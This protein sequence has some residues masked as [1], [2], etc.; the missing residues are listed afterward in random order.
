MERRRARPCVVVASPSNPSTLPRA[1]ALALL[2]SAGGA[3]R[4]ELP[5]TVSQFWDDLE[6]SF[7]WPAPAVLANDS[8]CSR[9][10]RAADD[11]WI[12]ARS[13]R[14]RHENTTSLPAGAGSLDGPADVAVRLTIPLVLPARN[15]CLRCLADLWIFRRNR[16]RP[17]HQPFRN[18]HCLDPTFQGSCGGRL[19]F[20]TDNNLL[21]AGT[22]GAERLIA[23]ADPGGLARTSPGLVAE[24][25]ARLDDPALSAPSPP[26]NSSLRSPNS[27]VAL[28]TGDDSFCGLAE[29]GHLHCWGANTGASSG[30]PFFEQPALVHAQQPIVSISG[31]RLHHCLL[32][33]A[34]DVYCWGNAADGA[35]G[36]V[37]PPFSSSFFHGR[38]QAV[39][40]ARAQHIEVGEGF[41]CALLSS[42]AVR[43]WGINTHGQLGLGHTQPTTV[44]PA[45]LPD[46]SLGGPAV[47]LSNG[48]HVSCVI[49]ADASVRCWGRADTTVLGDTSYNTIGDNELPSSVPPVDVGGPAVDVFVGQN[50]ACVILESGSVRCWGQGSG[51][52]TGL[53]ATGIG[54]AV[55]ATLP[56]VRVGGEVAFIEGYA[57][58]CI[59]YRSGQVRC[60]GFNHDGQNGLG[61]GASDAFGDNE[62]PDSRFPIDVG[63]RVNELKSTYRTVCAL[64]EHGHLRCWGSNRQEQYGLATATV[65]GVTSAP[66]TLPRDCRV[67][68]QTV[69]SCGEQ[70]PVMMTML[71]VSACTLFD[72]FTVR[73]WGINQDGEL[74]NPR[75]EVV[76]DDEAPARGLPAQLVG[77]AVQVGSGTSGACALMDTAE[78][79]CWG[80]S[81][82]GVTGL[83]TP[84]AAVHEPFRVPPLN[85]SGPAIQVAVQDR[86]ACAVLESGAVECWGSIPTSESSAAR[87]EAGS[88]EGRVELPGNESAVAMCVAENHLCVQTASDGLFC[89]GSN[90]H[91]Q[92]GVGTAST[93]RISV[94]TAV[95]LGEPVRQA[96]CGM[97]FTCVTTV[98]GRAKCWGSNDAGQLGIGG[99]SNRGLGEPVSAIPSIVLRDPTASV[100]QVHAGASIA[101]A[102]T[103]LAQLYCWGG[104]YGN[105]LAMFPSPDPR[106]ATWSNPIDFGRP[107]KLVVSVSGR[108]RS[109]G[110]ITSNGEVF[111]WGLPDAGALGRPGVTQATTLTPSVRIVPRPTRVLT[112]DVTLILPRAIEGP[113]DLLTLDVL[114]TQLRTLPSIVRS[115]VGDDVAVRGG[116]DLFREDRC[117]FTMESVGLTFVC[118]APDFAPLLTARF[119]PSAL[120]LTVETSTPL[121]AAGGSTLRVRGPPELAWLFTSGTPT[122][123]VFDYRSL[124]ATPCTAVRLPVRTDAS[125]FECTAGPSAGTQ[126]EL[127]LTFAN[128]V[129]S[130]R[131]VVASPSIVYAAP[132]ITA[133]TPRADLSVLGDDVMLIQGEHFGIVGD[134][135]VTFFAPNPRPCSL[136]DSQG[137]FEI[138]CSSPAGAG[139]N[140]SVVV[141]VA[142]Q[143]SNRIFVSYARPVVNSVSPSFALWGE[144]NTNFTICGTSIGHPTDTV[145]V[146]RARL[147][148]VWCG[149]VTPLNLSCVLCSNV[150]GAN[151]WG[152]TA[153]ERQ[154]VELVVRDQSSGDTRGLWE[155][156]DRPRISAVSALARPSIGGEPVILAISSV[157]RSVADVDA[158]LV[159]SE[160]V[161]SVDWES[162]LQVRFTLPR[163][164]G[165]QVP[166]VIRTR[167]GV[168]SEAE[169]LSY[170]KPV[171]T[172]IT[173][174]YALAGTTEFNA[175]LCGLNFGFQTSDY[176]LIELGGFSC[177]RVRHLA[178]V[179]TSVPGGPNP[180]L[181][182]CACTILDASFG[183]AVGSAGA[184]S[185][186]VRGQTSERAAGLFEGLGLPRISLVNPAS[187]SPGDVLSIAG[188]NFG[189]T[190]AD[191]RGAAV[192]GVPCSGT[193]WIGPGSVLCTIPLTHPAWQ[194]SLLGAPTADPP[195]PVNVTVVLA[196]GAESVGT[197]QDNDDAPAAD[198]AGSGDDEAPSRVPSA[199]AAV[200]RK[201]VR[202]G[203]RPVFAPANVTGAREV[204]RPTTMRIEWTFLSEAAELNASLRAVASDE[205]LRRQRR[206]RGL[207]ATAAQAELTS[208]FRVLAIPVSVLEAAGGDRAAVAASSEVV[209]ETVARA[210][211]RLTLSVDGGLEYHRVTL[212]GLRAVPYSL[213]VEADNLG[214]EAVA[215]PWTTPVP[216]ACAAS[217]YLAN[218]GASFDSWV[219]E[220][221]PDEA[222][223]GGLP[224][225]NVTARAGFWRVPW[226]PF[227]LGFARCPIPEACVGCVDCVARAEEAARR[228]LAADDDDGGAG[229]SGGGAQDDGPT[230]GDATVVDRFV[231]V[232]VPGLEL[233]PDRQEGCRE[234]YQG[235]LCVTCEDGYFRD[236]SGR[237]QKCGSATATGLRL[238]GVSLL[239]A[240]L[241][242]FFLYRAYSNAGQGASL[243]VMVMK[244]VLTHLQTVG[245]VASVPLQWPAAIS[246]VFSIGTTTS[247][248]SQQGI[249]VECVLDGSGKDPFA[250]T[251]ASLVFPLI[252][253][254]FAAL[255]WIAVL[256]LEELKARGGL[257]A[258]LCGGPRISRAHTHRPTMLPSP[259]AHRPLVPTEPS[260]TPTPDPSG[261]PSR[262][263][264]CCPSWFARLFAQ[265]VR[266]LEVSCVVLVFLVHP[267]VSTAT[268]RL[269]S[270]QTVAPEGDPSA[271]Q[272]RLLI[273]PDV[274]CDD[275]DTLHRLLSFSLPPLILFSLGLPLAAL[276]ILVL[277]RARLDEPGT[278]FLFGFLYAGYRPEL[279]FWE[280]L[281]Q[282]RKIL[283]AAV[284]ALVAPYGIIP[285]LTAASMVVTFAIVA[286]AWWKP[287]RSV[288]MN[289]LEA[290]SLLTAGLTLTAGLYIA[291]MDQT[292]ASGIAASFFIVGANAVFLV[293]AVLVGLQ[294]ARRS[295]ARQLQLQ[296]AGAR[297]GAVLR[298]VGLFARAGRGKEK[299]RRS[300]KGTEG[301]DA[302]GGGTREEAGDARRTSGGEATRGALGLG[303]SANPMFRMTRRPT[304]T[305]R[306]G[307]EPVRVGGG[308][309]R[310]GTSSDG[311]VGLKVDP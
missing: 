268:L 124:S 111:T 153:L 55:P 217:E 119:K 212:R 179:P 288:E 146:L 3:L 103:H 277:R 221:C 33:L 26:L 8:A 20:R 43:C 116:S 18:V 73:C 150:S 110:V 62:H 31:G 90:S 168:L 302:K 140:V 95:T 223:C 253:L 250:Q 81:S 259:A 138:Q 51:G 75:L 205:P 10:V 114:R 34:G 235:T 35:L 214:F 28:S 159:G 285:Q 244:E 265:W 289:A 99:L 257:T 147:G 248:I 64:V 239:I 60:L 211:S 49:L 6:L 104:T 50:T 137:D 272:Q 299:K 40:G 198:D 234:G 91:G 109:A 156:F 287:F 113:N 170:D 87:V 123:S 93:A 59:V 195:A 220:R 231:A 86:Y 188:E 297:G 30:V 201:G 74:G 5:L 13:L 283:L 224:A 237:C 183:W 120:S 117:L 16:W 238:F 101:C 72:D 61:L 66:A 245:I 102:M 210:S 291:S 177:V 228:Q 174:S 52:S 218:Q 281:I 176:G 141:T 14:A 200:K 25:A 142:G 128:V 282:L 164:L 69:F 94:L 292:D 202:G 189:R 130:S 190:P 301:A 160:A 306:V 71:H 131:V 271:S 157:G 29:R 182:C 275:P 166:V 213:L 309:S 298:A 307:G 45:E 261:V 186:T 155:G 276:V 172:F 1:L 107:D 294:R 249:T 7:P 180:A 209:T 38:V 274:R 246:T 100:V 219:C 251:T 106:N 227:G 37:A 12:V 68:H 82:D 162:P 169:F 112:S 286:H 23:L 178:S 136:L 254:A 118:I 203:P 121:A 165:A 232:A 39:L 84:A 304:M 77:R 79:R 300:L 76:G 70:V 243:E 85:L 2:L 207:A 264:S 127:R 242:G 9:G 115:R 295:L 44:T 197:D 270:C 97:D 305:P 252:L 27:L 167:A 191:V 185:V 187:A 125:T 42:G 4:C 267:S 293:A 58:T 105:L 133:I 11:V 173:P 139:T 260:S 269:L 88:P 194:S 47:I 226:S 96:A 279:C 67:L 148:S 303:V 215:S 278:K 241:L 204:D 53:G 57:S 311:D 240:T 171:V 196:T 258:C 151:G 161:A 56:F 21:G 132:R 24:V 36:V 222:E 308:T 15:L 273:W 149:T 108:I 216:A 163:G 48:N 255:F 247:S 229:G 280:C 32:D 19:V 181:R 193:E 98:A 158:I 310:V 290:G 256:L 225:A 41:T 233:S 89:A 154:V 78:V 129:R 208:S 206:T 143:E 17:L 134:K 126:H 263:A 92:L 296:D 54:V 83:V 284:I 262:C 236:V 122:V 199:V 230:A 65:V 184:A 175:T 63:G 22:F 192:G 145:G 135:S 144:Q 152:A 46:T 266:R 80:S